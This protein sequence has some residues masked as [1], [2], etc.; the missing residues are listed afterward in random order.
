MLR[1][2]GEFRHTEWVASRGRGFGRRGWMRTSHDQ[3]HRHGMGEAWD[4]TTLATEMTF[5]EWKDRVYGAVQG[6]SDVTRHFHMLDMSRG[7]VRA[8]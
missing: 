7:G 4:N 8:H 5:G 2:V 3:L 6:R 1:H